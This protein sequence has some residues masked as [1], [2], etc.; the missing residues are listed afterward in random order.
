MQA[1]KL[2]NMIKKTFTKRFTIPLGFEFFNILLNF[3]D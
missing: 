1:T 2:D 3:M